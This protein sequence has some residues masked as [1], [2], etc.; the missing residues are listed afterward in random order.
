MNDVQL[1]EDIKKLPRHIAIIMDGN[2]RWAKQHNRPRIM[3]HQEGLKAAREIVQVCDEFKIDVLTL[4]AFSSE[5]WRRPFQEVKSLM[6]LFLTTLQ[7]ELDKLCEAN[8]QL[9]I[10]GSHQDFN[11]HL[12]RWIVKAQ[13]VTAKNTGLKLVIAANYSGQWDIIQAVKRIISETKKHPIDPDHVTAGWFEQHLTLADL[14]LPDLLI[15][16]GGEFRMSNFLLWHLAYTELYFTDVLWPD[17]TK[18]ELKK[19]LQFY[20]QRERRFGFTS[21]QLVRDVS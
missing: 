8:V 2:G 20:A 6:S 12:I 13:Q 19:A 9:R 3:G 1:R 16:T 11:D 7:T 10:V 14:P 17:F 18:E 5:N 4:F 21:E 15:R